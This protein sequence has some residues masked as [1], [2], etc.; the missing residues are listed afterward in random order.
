MPETTDGRL[1]HSL[2]AIR[3]TPSWV[4]ISR[5]AFPVARHFASYVRL[6]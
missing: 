1:G 3:Y 4:S 6:N 2:F 5:D